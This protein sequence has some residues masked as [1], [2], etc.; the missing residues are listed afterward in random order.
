M[1]SLGGERWAEHSKELPKLIL[2]QYVFIQN[3]KAAGNL[4]KRWDKTGVVLEDLGYDK[5]SVK[6]DG[7]LK[8]VKP[9]V[10]SPLL[11]GPRPDGCIL[12]AP[13]GPAAPVQSRAPPTVEKRTC[14]PSPNFECEEGF[15]E[16][17]NDVPEPS[18][19][20][21]KP[22]APVSPAPRSP[23]SFVETEHRDYSTF[24]TTAVDLQV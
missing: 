12:R 7:Y 18:V 9:A 4:A 22:P 11:R 23:T 1:V 15:V 21:P 16:A 13:V 17:A 20:A 2:G 3:R 19:L 24:D 5:Y 10:E 14:P 8:N 6:V